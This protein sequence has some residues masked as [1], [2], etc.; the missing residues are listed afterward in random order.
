MEG[1]SDQL[2]IGAYLTYNEVV[3]GVWY[4]GI[5]IKNYQ[6]GIHNN[7]S[8]IG[9]IGLVLGNFRIGYSYDATVSRLARANTGGAHELSLTFV[10]DQ[11]S[12]G[13]KKTKHRMRKP[14]CPKF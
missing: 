11:Q 13:K 1:K 6:P 8:V 9:L 4:K 2:D 3:V 12:N 5:P 10:F 7:E 14:V